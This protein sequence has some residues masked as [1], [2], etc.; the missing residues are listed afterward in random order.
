MWQLLLQ[1]YDDVNKLR[2]MQSVVSNLSER[3]ALGLQIAAGDASIRAM[4]LQFAEFDLACE[5]TCIAFVC[6]LSG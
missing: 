5:S 1:C 2:S 3:E 4:R 6:C